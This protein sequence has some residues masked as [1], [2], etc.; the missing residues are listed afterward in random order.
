MA[1]LNE[2]RLLEAWRALD[3]HTE[4]R[5]WKIL[6]I[7]SPRSPLLLAG[8]QHPLNQESMLIGFTIAGL[9]KQ[10]ALPQ[11]KG[12]NLEVVELPF[13]GFRYYC[14]AV[15]RQPSASLEIFSAMLDDIVGVLQHATRSE[16]EHIAAVI[17]RI[18]GWQRFMSRDDDGILRSEQELGLLGEIQVLKLLLSVGI[19]ASGALEW[20]QGPLDSLHDFVAPRGDL[21]VKASTKS[22]PFSATIGSLDQLDETIVQPLYIAAVQFSLSA[23]GFSLPQHIENVRQLLRHEPAMTVVFEGRLL[24]SG[25]HKVSANRYHRQFSYLTTNFYEVNDSLPH[26]IKGKVPKG[27]TDAIYQIEIDATRSHSLD[28]QEV[29]QQIG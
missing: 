29:L 1:T 28:L 24:A 22:G 14:L 12:F 21:E 18:V 3:E 23:N 10:T 7:S 19:P 27:V 8:R 20:W 25:Y 13:Q 6:P 15:T 11:S 4:R 5:G 9:P 2:E 16:A 17:D 26:L